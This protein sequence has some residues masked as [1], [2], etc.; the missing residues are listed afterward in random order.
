MLEETKNMLIK[1]DELEIQIKQMEEINKEYKDLKEQIKK[2][3][4]KI[5]RENNLEQIKWTTPNGTK[6]T[7]TL[8]HTAEIEYEEVEVLD[9]EKLKKEY[10]DVY[11]KCLVKR[12]K[13]KIIKNATSDTLRITL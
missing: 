13:E 12:K 3:M 6:I 11:K 8:G 5:G 1:L 4:S 7:C 10:E 2:E 9:E